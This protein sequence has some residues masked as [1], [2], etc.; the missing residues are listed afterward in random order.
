MVS[1]VYRNK[2]EGVIPQEQRKLR[3]I[4][5][6]MDRQIDGWID[7]LMNGWNYVFRLGGYLDDFFFNNY[8]IQQ[9]LS[10]VVLIKCWLC[11]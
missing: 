10:L 4:D 8:L 9:I 1:I 6:W 3:K 2:Q 11:T 7:G 5:G